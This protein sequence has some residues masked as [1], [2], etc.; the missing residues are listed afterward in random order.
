[1]NESGFGPKVMENGKLSRQCSYGEGPWFYKRGSLYYM[2]YA[3]FGPTGG[4]EH[5]AYS[6]SKSATGPWEY[7]GVIMPSQGAAIQTIRV[8]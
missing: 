2:V 7:Q 3:A 4:A 6:T 5:L 8:L 1:M